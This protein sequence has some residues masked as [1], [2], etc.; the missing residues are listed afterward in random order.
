MESS[1]RL[2][3]LLLG[4]PDEPVVRSIDDLRRVAAEVS[5]GHFLEVCSEFLNYLRRTPLIRVQEEYTRCFDLS[6]E[7]SMD[8]TLHRG[9]ND[10]ER[11]RILAALAGL[12]R[13]EGL[14]MKTGELPDHLPLVLEFLSIASKEAGCRIQMECR[15]PVEVL[16]TRLKEEGSPYAG[17]MGLA[18]ELMM[19]DE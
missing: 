9:G 12:Y 16:A 7:T 8:L 14:E 15:E 4:Y 18:A 17:L 6:P 13:E 11:S 5:D 1:L 10:R 19:N 3:S 2:I